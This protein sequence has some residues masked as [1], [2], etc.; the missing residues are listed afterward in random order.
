MF[1]G[2]GGFQHFQFAGFG[3]GD[4][5]KRFAFVDLIESRNASRGVAGAVGGGARSAFGEP[6]GALLAGG[7]DAETA[8]LEVHGFGLS[9]AIRLVILEH[10]PGNYGEFPRGGDNGDISIFLL[11]GFPEE[12]AER[13]GVR[14]DVLGGLDEK[15]T[16][17][18]ASLLG[19]AS[20]IALVVELMG[21]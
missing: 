19:D 10:M 20:V 3:I 13:S 15:P 18:G 16:G 7:G 4:G 21:D 8:E 17:V 2:P 11:R 12:M 1:R 5:R 9:V 14:I 6:A